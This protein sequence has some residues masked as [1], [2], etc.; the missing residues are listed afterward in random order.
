MA[1]AVGVASGLGARGEAPEAAAVQLRFAFGASEC[2]SSLARRR[3]ARAGEGWAPDEVGREPVAA[4]GCGELGAAD[5]GAGARRTRARLGAPLAK[6]AVAGRT[7]EGGIEQ[8]ALPAGRPRWAAAHLSALLDASMSTIPWPRGQGS[9]TST[10]LDQTAGWRDG[11][12]QTLARCAARAAEGGFPGQRAASLRRLPAA[13]APQVAQKTTAP[14]LAPSAAHNVWAWSARATRSKCD[15]PAQLSRTSSG[16][17]VSLRQLTHC[18][19][20]RIGCQRCAMTRDSA[21][22]LL[23]FGGGGER[24]P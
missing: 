2:G 14:P 1:P 8:V 18:Q 5:G 16:I 17:R 10:S 11:V 15:A 7:A 3:L 19:P 9:P 13:Y 4:E 22:T 21:A 12:L 6:L 23:P 24:S 20:E